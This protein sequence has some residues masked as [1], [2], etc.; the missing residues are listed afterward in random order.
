[1]ERA[2]DDRR[3]RSWT[4]ED[5][6]RALE[7]QRWTFAKTMKWCPHE[8]TLRKHWT[9]DVPFT[10]VVR[11]LNEKGYKAFF[12]KSVNTY[13]QAGPMKYWAMNSNPEKAGLINRTYTE[14]TFEEPAKRW[15]PYWPRP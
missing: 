12:G 13:W 14:N 2:G 6:Q 7:G 3:G 5:I 4:S 11:Y 15:A 1:M 10:E 8:Y 9:A